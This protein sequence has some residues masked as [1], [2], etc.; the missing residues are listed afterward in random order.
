MF[1][2]FSDLR[3]F[4]SK[5]SS[6]LSLDNLQKEQDEDQEP[7]PPPASQP[8]KQTSPTSSNS[9]IPTTQSIIPSFHELNEAQHLLHEKD[10][11]IQF[12]TNN[13]R[14]LQEELIQLKDSNAKKEKDEKREKEKSEREKKSLLQD[15]YLLQS[16]HHDLELELKEMQQLYQ[17]KYQ[18][19]QQQ[20]QRKEDASSIPCES[21]V[22]Y[23][24]QIETIENDYQLQIENLNKKN[25]KLHK[26]NK[27]FEKELQEAQAQIQALTQAA[28]AIALLP[29]VDQTVESSLEA[30]PTIAQSP[31]NLN[32][33][34]LLEDEIRKSLQKEN[35]IQS[36]QSHMKEMQRECE[37]LKEKQHSQ[38][39]KM[40]E[41]VKG[42]IESQRLLQ[43]EKANLTKT[44]TSKV[45]SFAFF[46]TDPHPSLAR[47][48][49]LNN[50]KV[51]SA[52]LKQI[53][54]NGKIYLLS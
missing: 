36:L 26:Q 16:K 8:P 14:E 41:K 9:T 10:S 53:S 2:Q 47:M 17:S 25:T 4:A 21:C 40:K 20:E 7:P 39:T 23:Q 1:S 29:K 30:E 34:Q 33:S 45:I 15:Y 31:E 48:L 13:F 28:A 43:L 3:S 18:Q 54:T 49:R 5:I 11:Q 51:N 50:W 35:E 44:L 42:F 46:L 6:E 24:S 22:S 38:T 37:E 27:K 52:L 12:L 19:E 32:L